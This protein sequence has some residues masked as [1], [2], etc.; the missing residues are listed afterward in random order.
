MYICSINNS[1]QHNERENNMNNDNI[2]ST[3]VNI[4]TTDSLSARFCSI[5][6]TN[7]AGET[8]RYLLNLNNKFTN[9]YRKDVE[10]LT[11][12]EVSALEIDNEVITNEILEKARVELLNSTQK[13][14]DTNFQ[15]SNH[16][17]TKNMVDVNSDTT[18]SIRYHEEKNQFYIHA[19]SIAKEV[20][21]KGE[22][23]EVKS[24]PL[25]IAKN[26]LKKHLELGQNSIRFFILTPEKVK[27]LSSNGD[28][29]EIEVSE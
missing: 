13:S 20:L 10:K 9:I 23:K 25:T 15:G 4:A 8:S 26:L 11:N 6:Y 27:K 21:K 7:K 1:Q 17:A 18:R 14:L 28:T 24:R 29:I 2:I 5:T 19:V 3:L 12:C 16:D 22:Y